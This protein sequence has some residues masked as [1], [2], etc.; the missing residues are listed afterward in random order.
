MGTQIFGGSGTLNRMM[1]ASWNPTFKEQRWAIRRNAD[2]EERIEIARVSGN[3]LLGKSNP[4]TNSGAL[5][6]APEFYS[7]LR[8]AASSR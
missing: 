8:V 1:E 4:E 5:H 3:R 6:R 2:A 7:E